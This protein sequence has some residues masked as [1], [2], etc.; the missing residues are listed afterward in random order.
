[1]KITDD[2]IRE[3]AEKAASKGAP[4]STK[5]RN[6]IYMFEEGAK[7]YRDNQPFISQSCIG[8]TCSVCKQPATHK[9][10]EEI[11]SDDPNPNRHNLTAYVCTEHFNQ[12]LKPGK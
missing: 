12:V 9:L 6:Y 7:W 5:K 3:E 11:A 1:M 8:E 2:K 10:G 4:Y